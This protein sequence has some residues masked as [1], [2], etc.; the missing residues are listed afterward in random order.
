MGCSRFLD[1]SRD[2]L[3]LSNILREYS[4][5]LTLVAVKETSCI[6]HADVSNVVIND[7]N[8]A[9]QATPVIT[10]MILNMRPGFVFGQISPYLEMKLL[11]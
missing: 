6:I 4:S 3:F 2:G 1:Q 9:Q 10:H 7:V 8:K 5:F 11:S